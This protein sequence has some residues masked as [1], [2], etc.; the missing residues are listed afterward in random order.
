MAY[1]RRSQEAAG[2]DLLLISTSP[3]SSIG[4]MDRNVDIK[5]YSD[6]DFRL[7][8]EIFSMLT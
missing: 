2:R 1:A 3:T 5:L 4:V 6:S 7:R 8:T